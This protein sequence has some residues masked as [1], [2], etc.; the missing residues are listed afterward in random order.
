[1]QKVCDYLSPSSPFTINP[2]SAAYCPGN[3]QYLLS[4]STIDY[5]QRKGFNFVAD[6]LLYV[7]F[8]T[9]LSSFLICCTRQEMHHHFVYNNILEISYK[10]IQMRSLCS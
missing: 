8:I 9:E 1:M 7:T 5:C 10:R 6:Q 2:N 4:L 3:Y